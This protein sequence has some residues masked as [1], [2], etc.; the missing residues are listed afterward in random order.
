MIIGL[1]YI[2]SPRGQLSDSYKPATDYTNPSINSL[3]I[4]WHLMLIGNITQNIAQS[5]L[6]AWRIECCALQAWNVFNR[7]ESQLKSHRLVRFPNPLA[8]G[9][10]WVGEAS[11]SKVFSFHSSNNTKSPGAPILFFILE[12]CLRQPRADGSHCDKPA[13]AVGPRRIGVKSIK[14]SDIS[15]GK[16]PLHKILFCYWLPASYIRSVKAYQEAMPTLK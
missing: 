3:G 11:C 9:R 2:W 1:A 7:W 13:T 6:N 10:K 14:M 15:I 4:L 16:W 8:F 5:A 12:I